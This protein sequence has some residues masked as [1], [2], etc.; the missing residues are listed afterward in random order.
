MMSNNP[1]LRSD[2][3]KSGVE[4]APH[5]SL[6]RSLGLTREDMRRPLIGIAHSQNDVV[7]GHVHMDTI[8]SAVRD[9]VLM[10]GGVPFAF[11]TIA[12]CDGIAMAHDVAGRHLCQIDD[13]LHARA[14]AG[15]RFW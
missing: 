1:K 15:G 8:V 3:V 11:P 6:F 2:S 12:V 7:P 13:G 4:R 9:G 5:R 14:I 10:A